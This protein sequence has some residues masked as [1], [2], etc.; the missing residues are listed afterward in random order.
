MPYACSDACR[1]AFCDACCVVTPYTLV[2]TPYILVVT[3][4]TPLFVTLY[5]N[6]LA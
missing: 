1:D 5:C 4:Y 3:P 2:V 6:V